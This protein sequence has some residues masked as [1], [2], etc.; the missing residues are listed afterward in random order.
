MLGTRYELP[1]PGALT[2]VNCRCGRRVLC[3]LKSGGVSHGGIHEAYA[4]DPRTQAV[5]FR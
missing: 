2:L 1:R 3:R 4:G 5:R